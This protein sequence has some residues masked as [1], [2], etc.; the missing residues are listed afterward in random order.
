[1]TQQQDR[2]LNKPVHLVYFTAGLLFFYIMTWTMDWIW[3]YFVRTPSQLFITISSA[4]F[5]LILGIVLYRNK[6]VYTSINEIATEVSKVTWP[7]RKEVKAATLVV[8][9]ITII[10]AAILGLFDAVWSQLTTT[11]YG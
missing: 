5:V 4:V 1:M 8:I 6:R 2:T 11:I 7:G 3:G 9:V 10:S